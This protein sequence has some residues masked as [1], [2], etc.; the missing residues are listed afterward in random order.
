[1]L[2][3]GAEL[4]GHPWAGSQHHCPVKLQSR[5]GCQLPWTDGHSHVQSARHF[6]GFMTD[7]W[8]PS[9]CLRPTPST[10]SGQTHRCC[11]GSWPKSST[12]G[13]SLAGLGVEQGTGPAGLSPALVAATQGRRSSFSLLPSPQHPHVPPQRAGRPVHGT[14]GWPRGRGDESH[15]SLG[16]GGTSSPQHRGP[17]GGCKFSP[18]PPGLSPRLRAL[19]GRW[20]GGQES[21][22]RHQSSPGTC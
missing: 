13:H 5:A 6:I 7:R 21:G 22:R 1:M 8:F 14:A 18:K 10:G 2:L 17:G 11:L 20:L 4:Q 16:C 9:Q 12:R 3:G 15:E 19:V